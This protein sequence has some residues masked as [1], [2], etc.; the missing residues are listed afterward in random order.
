MVISGYFLW[1][2]YLLKQFFSTA[3]LSTPP[4]PFQPLNCSVNYAATTVYQDISVTC[5]QLICQEK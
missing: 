5:L 3:L 1:C 2:K 4:S